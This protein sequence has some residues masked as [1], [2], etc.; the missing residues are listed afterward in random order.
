MNV[1]S[2]SIYPASSALFCDHSFSRQGALKRKFDLLGPFVP[3]DS[4]L[5]PSP[6]MSSPPSPSRTQPPESYVYSDRPTSPAGKPSE[7]P[8]TTLPALTASL[9]IA[10][11]A[12]PPSFFGQRVAH[13]TL[14]TAPPTAV[15][16]YGP[17]GNFSVDR[18]G[19]ASPS[20]PDASSTAGPSTSMRGGRRS[21]THVA[22]A[23][24][25]CKRAHLSCD[26]Q[27]PCARCVSSGKQVGVA[28]LRPPGR[29][30]G[31]MC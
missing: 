6:P 22:S 16:H 10:Q 27:R 18:P 1:K 3:L 4:L 7:R 11:P 14:A 24:I 30:T 28:L 26:I 13:P 9:P 17:V 25:N 23:C 19:P 2:D 5:Y 29:L 20:I 15:A 8:I 21:K 31:R 12:L